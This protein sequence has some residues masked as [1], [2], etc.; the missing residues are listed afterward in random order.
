MA[1]FNSEHYNKIKDLIHPYIDAC[2]EHYRHGKLVILPLYH[3][4]DKVNRNGTRK[5]IDYKKG[6]QCLVPTSKPYWSKTKDKYKV[7]KVYFTK[8]QTQC[9]IRH[10]AKVKVNYYCNYKLQ[11]YVQK[12]DWS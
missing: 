4:C 3:G 6:G 8:Y 11:K 1:V 2:I 9:S 10:L 7:K 12:N 5:F